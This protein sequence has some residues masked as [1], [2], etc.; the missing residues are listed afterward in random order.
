MGRPERPARGPRALT[1]MAL[2]N[3]GQNKAAL[4]L[5]AP[6]PGDSVIELGCGPGMGVR[7][8]LK[9]VGR[10]G[11]VAGVD[12]SATAAHYATHVAHRAVLSGRAVIMRAEA[13]D[14]PFRD[15]MFDRAFAVNSF[16][17]WPDPAR[18]LREIARVLAPGGRL[19]ITQRASQ[20]RQTDQFRRRRRRHGSHRPSH[21][22][23][24]GARLAHPRRTLHARRLPLAGGE[25]PGRTAGLSNANFA[26]VAGACACAHAAGACN[27]LACD[28]QAHVWRGRFGP[29]GLILAHRGI[30]FLAVASVCILAAI[31]AEARIAATLVTSISVI[32]FLIAYVLAGSPKRLRT[33]ALVDAVALAPL[34]FVV[35][36]IWPR[37]TA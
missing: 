24:E 25:R 31:N 27:V 2:K 9:R 32:G 21:R 4:D 3:G 20:P 22:A 16:Q 11:F 8:A 33:I 5:L 17:F 1:A 14:L 19:V 23:V 6:R 18:A 7:A 15:S 37:L 26:G 10:E 13:A 30:L 12:Q 28:A 29:L 34:A 35:A 36:D